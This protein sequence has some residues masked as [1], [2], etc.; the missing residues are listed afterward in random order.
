MALIHQHFYELTLAC[1]WRGRSKQRFI[2]WL[3]SYEAC[4]QR[5]IIPV[6]FKEIRVENSILWFVQW[7]YRSNGRGRE[8]Q[9][10]YINVWMIYGWL[11]P[12]MVY[13]SHLLRII[14]WYFRWF[15]WANLPGCYFSCELNESHFSFMRINTIN[16]SVW[17]H[18]LDFYEWKWSHCQYWYNLV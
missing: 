16:D 10:S 14:P 6:N 18:R 5:V 17:F 4:A 12:N 8:I 11:H 13:T 1:I 15:G 9:L 2:F 7:K 3:L